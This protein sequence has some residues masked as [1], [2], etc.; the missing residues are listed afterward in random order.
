MYKSSVGGDNRGIAE[1]IMPSFISA[2]DYS[3]WPLGRAK[4]NDCTGY[5]QGKTHVH[6][7]DL[8]NTLRS[9]G[10]QSIL[11]KRRGK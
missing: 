5:E 9:D 4:W 1:D 10:F 6:L 7:S 8:V 2:L 11:A 3:L